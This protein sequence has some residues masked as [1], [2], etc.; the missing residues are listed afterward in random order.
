MV[1][2]PPITTMKI[3]DAV[4]SDGEGGVG[5]DAQQ[6]QVDQ[7]AGGAGAERGDQVDDELGAE[8][9]DAE[10]LASRLA[11][12]HGHQPQAAARAQER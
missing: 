6:V 5:R 3:V 8:H 12:A 2:M 7:R 4:Q 9:V 10:A 11:V 1:P